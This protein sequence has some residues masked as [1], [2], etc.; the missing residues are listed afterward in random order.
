[1]LATDGLLPVAPGVGM[2]KRVEELDLN[3]FGES[4]VCPAN[5]WETKALTCY[6]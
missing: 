5:I 2:V 3:P 6:F 1:M 4:Y